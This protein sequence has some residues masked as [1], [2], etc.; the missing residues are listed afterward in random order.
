MTDGLDVHPQ[1]R[2]VGKPAEDKIPMAVVFAVGPGVAAVERILDRMGKH[3]IIFLASISEMSRLRAAARASLYR[4]QAGA[5]ACTRQGR[6]IKTG[7][8]LG[9]VTCW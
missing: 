8:D 1:L 4:V 2:R 9:E 5:R 7:Y 6:R 3:D